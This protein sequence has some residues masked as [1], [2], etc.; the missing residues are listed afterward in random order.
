MSYRSATVEPE[1][2]SNIA[3]PN[4]FQRN[5]KNGGEKPPSH[6]MDSIDREIQGLDINMNSIESNKNKE[7]F[8]GQGE[9]KKK[10]EALK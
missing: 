7:E 2:D 10:L 3:S 4:T 1:D 8:P 5:L 9:M 6:M